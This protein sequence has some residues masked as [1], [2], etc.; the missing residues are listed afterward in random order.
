LGD[1]HDAEDAAQA[2]FLVLARRAGSIKRRDSVAS[3]L[4]GVALRVAAKVRRAA[5]RR[6][7]HERK[8]FEIGRDRLELA[9]TRTSTAVADDR[10]A[11]LH[12][13][14]DRQPEHFRSPLVLLHLEGLTQEPAA[15]QLRLPLGTL[16]S[17]SARGRAQLKARLEKK[18][19]GFAIGLLDAAP[20]VHVALS[21]GAT[22]AWAEATVKLALQF[23]R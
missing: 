13:K 23:S 5:A 3:W 18:G 21:T 16:Q 11:E 9:E 19:A 10:W 15:A 20:N 22:S 17:R 12:Q 8:A 1:R 6:R 14:L 7:A 4:H 2:V